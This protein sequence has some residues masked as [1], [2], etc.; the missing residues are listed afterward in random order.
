[1]N[2]VSADYNLLQLLP[3]RACKATNMICDHE[4]KSQKAIIED[5]QRIKICPQLTTEY[6][7]CSLKF[8]GENNYFIG[9]TGNKLCRTVVIFSHIDNA[10]H[11]HSDGGTLT[12]LIVNNFRQRF[13][14]VQ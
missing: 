7:N 12:R 8:L 13:Q 3:A 1:M 6:F 14:I 9:D 11:I 2:R 5:L 4:I 10:V